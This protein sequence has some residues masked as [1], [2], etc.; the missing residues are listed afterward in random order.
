MDP[1]PL[2]TPH[3]LLLTNGIGMN[4]ED[5]ARSEQHAMPRSL[6]GATDVSRDANPEAL[7]NGYTRRACR[8]TDDEY[9]KAHQDA[10]YDEIKVDGDVGFVE[11]N[12]V[13]DRL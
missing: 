6:A 10:F 2:L 8:P 4:I 7:R 9:T 3:V 13:L 11:R 1:T 5:Q 12:N